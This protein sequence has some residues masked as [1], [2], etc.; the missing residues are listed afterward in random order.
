[1]KPSNISPLDPTDIT[2]FRNE[3]IALIIQF[4]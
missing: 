4:P 3:V 2:T 1:M